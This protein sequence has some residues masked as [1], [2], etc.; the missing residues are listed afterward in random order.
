MLFGR[1][2]EKSQTD[3]II[4]EEILN[5]NLEDNEDLS[6]SPE[7]PSTRNQMN[8]AAAKDEELDPEA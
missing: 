5:L 1:V 4:D 2:V 6:G 3:E 8:D 7:E